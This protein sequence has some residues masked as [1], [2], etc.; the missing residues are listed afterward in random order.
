MQQGRADGVVG[1]LA[2][3]MVLVG[4]VPA[5]AQIQAGQVFGR[6]VDTTGAVLPGVMVTLQSPALITPQSV[7]T[8]PSGAYR[9]PSVPIGT[10]TVRF[11]L[12]GFKTFV[13]QGVQITVGF[14]AEIN[15]RLEISTV[16]ETITISG[17]SPVVDTTA[18]KTGETFNKLMLESLPSAR[19]PWVILEQTPGVVMDRQNVGGSQSG[20]QSDFT[21]HGGNRGNSM[22]NVDGVTITDMAATGASPTYYDFDAF[23]EIQIQTGGNDASLQTG[24][25]NLNL[26]TKSG[27]NVFRGSG[28]FFV[29][30]DNLQSDNVTQALKDDGAD[31][32]NPIKNIKDFGFEVGGPIVRNQA[33]FWGGY[34][35]QDISVGI[36]GFTV[37]GGDP[38]NPKD[39]APDATILENYNTKLQYQPTPPHKFTFLYT[40]ADKVRNA[41]GASPTTRIE[42]TFRQSGPTKLYKGSWQWI[43]SDRMTIETQG[44][45]VDGG[46]VLD[47]HDPSLEDVQPLFDLDTGVLSR[48]GRRAGPFIR[49][50]TEIKTDVN[51]FASSWLGGDH[52]MKLGVRWRDTPFDSFGKRGGDAS[53]RVDAGVPV[54]ADLYRNSVSLREMYNVS[55]YVNDSYNRGRMRLN[56]GVRVD[57]QD[58]RAKPATVPANPIIPDI[59]PALNFP[60]ADSGVTF[61]DWS[62]RFGFTYDV[63]GNGKTVAKASAAIYYGQ[64]IFTGGTLNP[65]GESRVRYRWTDLNGDLFVQANELDLSRILSRSNYNTNDPAAVTSPNRVDQNLQNDRTREVILGLDHELMSDFGVGVTYIYR[66]YDRFQWT[67]TNGVSSGD[68]VPVAYTASCGNATCDQSSY[69]V[70]YYQLP[71]SLPSGGTLTNQN[72]WR[73]FN[74][75]EVTARKRYSDRWMLNGSLALGSTPQHFGEDGFRDPTNIEFIE[76]SQDNSRNARWVVKLSGLYSFPWGVNASAFFNAR[77]GFP[78]YRSIRSPNRSGGIGRANVKFEKDGETRYPN[79]YTLDAR[80]E[81]AFML[82]T[83]RLTASLDV[84]NIGNANTVLDRE[85]RQ[86]VSS[87]NR[88][89]EILAPRVTRFG[90]RVT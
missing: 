31:S 25:I 47:F 36:L 5:G 42:S 33:W 50:Q 54:E 65:V 72:F 40:Y 79:F 87:A 9:F 85:G 90:V 4:A 74:G 11:E 37:P 55:A 63:R 20:Q 53:A 80:L 58:D 84:F 27:S 32:G 70:T 71:F 49:P 44:S 67:P 57:Y 56:F 24:G 88:V 81:K 77:Q 46:F 13:R 2:L 26:I 10:Y 89:F 28:R 66:K 15:A 59:L 29:V 23:E 64:G 39:L 6:A 43:A 41:R 22:W 17:E 30:D 16:E 38:N 61:A 34:G 68:Y 14:N 3:A 78:F 35:K 83:V 73:N 7:V 19:D 48:S 60:G 8:G 69:T 12:P 52:S 62:P 18:V 21:V 86:N 51:Y 1:A 75:L 76:G 45:Y 82:R